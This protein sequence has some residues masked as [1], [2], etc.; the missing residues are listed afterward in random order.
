[1]VRSQSVLA[2]RHKLSQGVVQTYSRHREGVIGGL[3]KGIIEVMSFHM[4]SLTSG[5]LPYLSPVLSLNPP[6]ACTH[7]C[8]CTYVHTQ[9]YTHMHTHTLVDDCIGASWIHKIKEKKNYHNK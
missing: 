1:M 4:F 6:A 7:A 9:V 3:G 5:Q 2:G 8:A